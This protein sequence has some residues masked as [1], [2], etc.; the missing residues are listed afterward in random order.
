MTN[1]PRISFCLL[2][3]VLYLTWNPAAAQMAGDAN[4]DSS[5]TAG[6]VVYLIQYLFRNGPPPVFWECGDPNTDC[7]V[8]A[9]DIVYLITY[10]FRN[11]PDPQILECG[12]SEPANLG[13]PI[14]TAYWD[15]MFR[16]SPDGQVAVWVSN[17][18]GSYG[19]GDIWYASWDSA[20]RAWSEP[21]NCG[22]NVNSVIEDLYPSLSPDGT[23]LY[24]LLYGRPGGYGGWDV[25]LSA[26]DSLNNEWGVIENLGPPINTFHSQWSPFLSPEGSK[27]YFSSNG[28]WVSE[29]TGTGWA[30]PSSLGPNVNSTGTEEEAT[31]TSDNRTL[32]FIRWATVPYICVS[33]R[34]GTD[35][36]PAL[37]LGPQVND[38]IG[39]MQPYIS[40]DGSQLYFTSGRPGG[41]GICDVWVSERIAAQGERRFINRE[42]DVSHVRGTE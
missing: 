26:W 35:W 1:I 17:K 37:K 34:I 14:N 33:Y 6:D 7:L 9:A 24:C 22:S 12:W 2:F 13:S 23:K 8:N 10:L 16:M 19:N 5:V 31:A 20:G 29:W 25:W 27:L 38:S 36:G 41:L 39:V 30:D 40:P 21:Q 15:H 32:Y 4:G 28:L 3:V 18:P 11:G 42:S